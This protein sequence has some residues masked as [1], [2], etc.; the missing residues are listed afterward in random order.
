MDA[1]T[2]S[3]SKAHAKPKLSF[4][5]LY[6]EKIHFLFILKRKSFDQESFLLYTQ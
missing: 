3:K 4:L 5:S 6:L 2:H 1:L